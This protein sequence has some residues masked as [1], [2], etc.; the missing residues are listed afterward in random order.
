VICYRLT[1]LPFG[2]N[3]SPFLLSAAVGELAATHT[4]TFPKAAMFVDRSTY[5]DDFVAGAED[6]SNVIAIYYQL[7]ALMRI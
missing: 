2:L 5:M 7:T 3:C 4:D 6:D 1:R